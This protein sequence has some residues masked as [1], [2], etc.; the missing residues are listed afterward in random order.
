MTSLNDCSTAAI[1][2]I[3]IIQ[4]SMTRIYVASWRAESMGGVRFGNVSGLCAG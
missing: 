1:S 2:A 3:T 4:M